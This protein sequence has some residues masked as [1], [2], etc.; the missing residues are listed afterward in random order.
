V[1]MVVTVP[2]QRRL[3]RLFPFLRGECPSYLIYGPLVFSPASDDYVDYLGDDWREALIHWASPM[4]CRLYDRQ[5]FPGEELVVVAGAMFSH[6]IS[7]GYKQPFAWT[8]ES[9][10]GTKIKNFTH[11]VEVIRDMS[12]TYVELTFAG[13]KRNVMVFRRNEMEAATQEVLKDNGI[14]SRCSA[15][16]RRILDLREE[17]SATP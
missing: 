15:D 14:R 6:R 2:V 1:E 7:K 5:S 8:V 13:R 10:N 9:M 16:V 17:R 11:L 12:D 4:V 3:G